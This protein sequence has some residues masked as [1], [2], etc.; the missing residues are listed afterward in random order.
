MKEESALAQRDLATTALLLTALLAIGF[1]ILAVSGPQNT[2]IAVLWA[3]GCLT[4]GFIVGFLFGFPRVVTDSDARAAVGGPSTGTEKAAEEQPVIAAAT[5]FAHRLAVN[6][7]LEQISDWLTKIIVGVGLVELKK[8]PS[9]IARAGRYVGT[10]FGGTAT[11]SFNDRLAAVIL[12]LFGGLGML[13]GYLL[14]RMFF[15]AAFRRADE[16]AF[17]IS[18]EQKRVLTEMPLEQEGEKVSLPPSTKAASATL[19]LAPQEAVAT[20]AN[21]LGTW[22]RV[23]FDNGQYENAISGYSEAVRLSPANARLRYGYAVALKYGG[24]PMP[25]YMRELDEA[26]RLASAS[27]D[28]ELRRQIYESFTFNALYLP[29]AGGYEQARNAALEYVNRTDNPP[30]GDIWLN[31]ACAYGQQIANQAISPAA[32]PFAEIR[33]RALRAVEAALAANPRLRPR[34]QQLLE[35][36]S[37]ADDD[38]RPF[39]EDPDF[40][41]V[42][43]L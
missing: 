25:E 30:S 36:R 24:H 6:T 23:Q 5:A 15:S 9:Y 29:P 42:A 32:A 7:N 19:A 12:I 17:G 13:A 41:R 34:I 38:L 35:G 16:N 1:G 26:R 18:N 33:A 14:T 11:D 39:S 8:L 37:P 4:S 2:G 21:S 22:A 40:R 27:S 43:G 20:S 31:L 28:P 10:A 3:L